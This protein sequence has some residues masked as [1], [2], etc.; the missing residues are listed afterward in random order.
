MQF[1]DSLRRFTDV[2]ESRITPNGQTTIKDYA[3][4]DRV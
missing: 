1:F 3:K 4:Y 2:V